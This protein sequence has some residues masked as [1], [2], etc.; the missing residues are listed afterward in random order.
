M[1][2][3]E[4][5]KK[6]DEY[7][8]SEKSPIPTGESFEGLKYF[9]VSEKY[10]VKARITILRESETFQLTTSTGKTREFRRYAYAD[11]SIDGKDCRLTILQ[12]IDDPNYFFLPFTDATS[13][14]ETYGAG[15]YLEPKMND[16][17]NFVID[18]NRAY[19]PYCA[20][21]ES[22]DCPIPPRENHLEVEIKAGEMNYKALK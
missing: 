14:K 17:A 11:F 8:R 18:F 19:N 4:L 22:Y 1:S 7:F 13:G 5:R 15:R 20:Y 2:V 16:L 21:N 9:P 6:Q 12:P 10:K 3:E